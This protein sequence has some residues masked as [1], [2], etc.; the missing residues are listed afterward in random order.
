MVWGSGLLSYGAE[1]EIV[2]PQS[3]FERIVPCD[4]LLP[5]ETALE[6]GAWGLGRK[7]LQKYVE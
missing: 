3:R 1:A 6:R 2:M 5:V 7:K 4:M